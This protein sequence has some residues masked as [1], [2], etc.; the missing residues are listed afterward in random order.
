MVEAR[1]SAALPP[2][3]RNIF[4]QCPVAKT[5]PNKSDFC[6]HAPSG[7]PVAAARAQ[8]RCA[9]HRAPK[10][11]HMTTTIHAPGT[12]AVYRSHLGL[13]ILALAMGGFGIGVTEFA[14]M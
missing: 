1:Y 12:P 14:M 6:R 10:S 8:A 5:E 9:L 7:R 11:R 2:T 3:S 13:A 4:R